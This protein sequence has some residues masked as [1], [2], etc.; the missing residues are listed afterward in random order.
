MEALR[1]QAGEFSPVRM[2]RLE[3]IRGARVGFSLL[4]LVLALAAAGK[5]TLYDT[6]D[7]DLFWHLRVADQLAALPYPQ[8]L[9]DQLSFAS[10]KTPWTPY[11]WLAELG[12]R[13]I[14]IHGGYQAAVA[15]QAIMAGAIVCLIAMIAVEMS[16]AR[17][18][19]SPSP[20]T[21]GEGW[22]EGESSSQSSVL[23]PQSFFS[24]PHP[25]PLPAYRE[26]GQEEQEEKPRYLTAALAAFVGE[27]LCLPYLSFRPVTL[28]IVILAVIAWLLQRDQR[29]NNRS[30]AVWF[31]PPLTAVLANVHLF[32]AFAPMAV[33]ALYVWK[34]P[35]LLF[36]TIFASL[37]TPMLP[38]AIATAWNCQFNDVMVNSQF[39][40]EIRPI[41]HGS[42]GIFS[43]ALVLLVIG[44]ALIRRQELS[45][46]QW[47]WLI[48]CSLLLLRMGRFATVFAIFAAPTLAITLSPLSNSVLSKT[49]ICRILAIVAILEF[50]K[51]A[52]AFP[53]P[54][55]PLSQWLNRMGPDA[56][57]YPTAAADFVQNHIAARTHRIICEFTW[58]GYL[59]W[60]LNPRWQLL[61][62]GRTQLYTPEFWK[63][64]YL[65]T[66]AQ[67]RAALEQISADAAIIPADGSSFKDDLI[68][69]G[70][71]IVYED[72]RAMV[73]VK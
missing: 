2:V 27:F 59:E 31:I 37:L 38:G 42:M 71:K 43:A 15:V 72:E 12:Q 22:G 62:D 47:L 53:T 33:F 14:W 30:R 55:V 39:I 5:A 67:R 32:V 40:T 52:S 69:F 57:G 19:Y 3:G 58:G 13:W 44:F 56:G 25:N 70:W 28:A 26:R 9:V 45:R 11:S 50:A 10:I 64:L 73:L 24:S 49:S 8:P 60:R 21:P 7:P 34:R 35:R 54:A 51:I 36:A 65:G 48:V 66:P 68:G 46:G 63:S 18:I 23:S 61:M 6:L 41:W 16:M 4:I 29:L 20:G 1:T 17:P